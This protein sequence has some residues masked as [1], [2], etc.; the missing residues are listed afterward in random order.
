MESAALWAK[1]LIR[2]SSSTPFPPP[3]PSYSRPTS[4]PTCEVILSVGCSSLALAGDAGPFVRR[5]R[6]R[7][8]AR[9]LWPCSPPPIGAWTQLV[10]SGL[11]SSQGCW[12]G[13]ELLA[14]DGALELATTVPFS[15]QTRSPTES[16]E[17]RCRH[18]S[19][20]KVCASS[21]WDPLA[22][23]A[24]RGPGLAKNHNVSHHYRVAKMMELAAVMAGYVYHHSGSYEGS[25]WLTLY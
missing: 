25:G 7:M 6:V 14:T 17:P 22:W 9:A 20:Y 4:G 1:T 24:R 10:R 21:P 18:P 16:R 2:P 3:G 11:P 8:Q 5:C 23:R 13:A 19:G 12:A 15:A